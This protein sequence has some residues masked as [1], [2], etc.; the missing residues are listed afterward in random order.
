M[1]D[2][3]LNAFFSF[4]V[5]VQ[6][7]VQ[8][9]C[10]PEARSWRQSKNTLKVVDALT[11]KNVCMRSLIQLALCLRQQ[12]T[13]KHLRHPRKHLHRPSNNHQKREEVC[14]LVR[15]APVL[16]TLHFFLLAAFVT[17]LD[18]SM[19]SLTPQTQ[20]KVH[21]DQSHIAFG[22]CSC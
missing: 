7:F 8:I 3:S 6:S 9:K 10:I 16:V 15:S 20:K 22:K 14:G 12:L 21:G 4:V 5:C 2:E 13:M 19:T 18:P 17:A 11:A 1:S